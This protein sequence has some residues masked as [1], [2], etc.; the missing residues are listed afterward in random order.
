M[1]C[2]TELEH[3]IDSL[4]ARILFLLMD[5]SV[6]PKHLQIFWVWLLHHN[7]SNRL[8]LIQCVP[9]E[10]IA[11]FQMKASCSVIRV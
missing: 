9:S 7:T 5:E 10:E 11:R 6:I 4:H 8:T 2:L 3:L 1:N